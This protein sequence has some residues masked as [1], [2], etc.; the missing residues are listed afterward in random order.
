MN[1]SDPSSYLRL[2]VRSEV[3]PLGYLEEKLGL[4]DE[5]S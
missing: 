4:S 3:H 1:L 5:G 2:Y